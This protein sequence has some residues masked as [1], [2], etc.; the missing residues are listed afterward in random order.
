MKLMIL[1]CTKL[2]CTIRQPLVRR[3]LAG[4]ESRRLEQSWLF[5]H[6]PLDIRCWLEHMEGTS[7]CLSRYQIEQ[8]F[9]KRFLILNYTMKAYAILQPPEHL[10]LEEFGSQ[11]LGLSWLFHRKPLDIRC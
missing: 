10:Q 3:R 11:Q 7:H 6:E 8:D 1:I 4:S 2:A 9:R 5:R